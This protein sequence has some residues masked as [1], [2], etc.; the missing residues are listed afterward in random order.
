MGKTRPREI[1]DLFED[2][3]ELL[4]TYLQRYRLKVVEKAA[5]L[6]ADV[7]SNTIVILCVL[8]AFLAASVTLAFYFSALLGSYT[9]G[10]GC[11]AAFYFLFALLIGATKKQIEKWQN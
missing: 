8:I 9:K 11:A 4:G 1:K 6:I 5:R 7:L 2:A 10:F 3:K